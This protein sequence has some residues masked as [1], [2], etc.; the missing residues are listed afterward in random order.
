MSEREGR[1]KVIQLPQQLMLDVFNWWRDPIQ[2]LAVPE[3]PGVPEDV[4]V[5]AVHLNHQMRAFE[6]LI[7]HP[8]FDV[9]PFG[10]QPP[11]IT[12]G[13]VPLRRVKVGK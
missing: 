11:V 7:W 12:A 3:L 2:W 1:F 13:N 4:E 10:R 5:T 6:L 9:V 8:S